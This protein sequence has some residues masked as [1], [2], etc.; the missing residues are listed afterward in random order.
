M[1]I[2]LP[3]LSSLAAENPPKP[4]LAVRSGSLLP[5]FAGESC[6]LTGLVLSTL[7][8]RSG[9]AMTWLKLVKLFVVGRR[10]VV[11]LVSLLKLLLRLL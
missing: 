4:V 9:M 10:L 5:G 7:L 3:V 8:V 1:S 2:T 11:V 6:F